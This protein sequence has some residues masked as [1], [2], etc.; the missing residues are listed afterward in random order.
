MKNISKNI[1][2]WLAFIQSKV[3]DIFD[4]GFKQISKAGNKKLPEDSHKARKILHKVLWF[5]WD[6]W[7]NYYKSY[8]KI[9]EKKPKKSEK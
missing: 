8:N 1:W 5:I 3:D 7:K 9:K 4:F 6:T 2:K